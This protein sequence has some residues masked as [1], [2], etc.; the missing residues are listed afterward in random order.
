MSFRSDLAMPVLKR[1]AG[2][3]AGQELLG[4]TP[5]GSFCSSLGFTLLSDWKLILGFFPDPSAPLDAP[6]ASTR[7]YNPNKHRFNY[8]MRAP[9]IF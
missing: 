1:T 9:S 2:N 8:Q 4:V 5:P 6:A 7:Q 3:T